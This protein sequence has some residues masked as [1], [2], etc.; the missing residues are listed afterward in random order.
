[1]KNLPRNLGFGTR[2]YGDA[3]FVFLQALH[4]LRR[5]LCAARLS[6]LCLALLV[7]PAIGASEAETRYPA[8]DYT[9]A[10]GDVLDISVW[11]NEEL[12]RRL[13]VLPDG[14]IHFPLIGEVLVQGKTVA[15]LKKEVEERLSGYVPKPVL[16]VI[17]NQVNSMLIYVLG[18]VNSPGRFLLQSNVNVLQGLAVAGGLN[19]YAERNKIKIFR[20]EGGKTAIFDFEYDTVAKGKDLSQNVVLKRGDVI[21]VP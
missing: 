17:V 21:V 4:A 6:L 9:L 15:Q 5:A 20:E 12:T 16:S 7:S 2:K 8:P 14:K 19:P 13:T 18:K 10:A 3:I 1:M 11:K